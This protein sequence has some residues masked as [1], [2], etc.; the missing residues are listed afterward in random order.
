MSYFVGSELLIIVFIKV[1]VIREQHYLIFR[2]YWLTFRKLIWINK[3]RSHNWVELH[4]LIN[5][6][7]PV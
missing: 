2:Y 6:N 7:N 1:D 4:S 3:S 5:C